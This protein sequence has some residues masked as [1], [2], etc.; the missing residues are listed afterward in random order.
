MYRDK[1]QNYATLIDKPTL[2]DILMKD[3]I[4]S[5]IFQNFGWMSPT[6][7]N[8]LSQVSCW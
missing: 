4:A 5:C 7:L 6:L 8:R 1:A 2:K 3:D